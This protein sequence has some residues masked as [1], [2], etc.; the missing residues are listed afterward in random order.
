MNNDNKHVMI[1]EFLSKDECNLILNKYLKELD[2][3]PA[4]VMNDTIDTNVRKSS[5]AF[6]DN[7]DI[8]DERLKAV[9]KENI[10]IKGFDV[11]GIGPYQFTKYEIG[12]HY[13]WHTDSDNDEYKD[14]Y[15]SIVI[16]LNDEYEGNTYA[17]ERGLGN[18]Y[19]FFSNILHRVIPVKKG[20]RYSLVNWV[21][22]E[23]IEGYKKTLL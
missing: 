16:Q 4:K 11:T 13:N 22:L 8:I 2:L 6:I 3:K 5:I 21:S 15:C 23:K 14:R 9:L 12:E 1:K 19:V 18:L 17:F 7:I 20:V 10:H